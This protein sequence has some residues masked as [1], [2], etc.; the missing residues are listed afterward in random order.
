MSNIA[1]PGIFKVFVVFEH[2]D[3]RALGAAVVD[4]WKDLTADLVVFDGVTP[5]GSTRY[6][7]VAY[8]ERKEGEAPTP[9]TWHY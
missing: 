8:S 9:G 6:D 2:P 5:D 4:M 1:S 7:H 3:G